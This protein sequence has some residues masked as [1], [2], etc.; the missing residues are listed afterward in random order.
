MIGVSNEHR[1]ASGLAAGDEV[2]VELVLDTAPRTVERAG[3]LRRGARRRPAARA[4]ST[5]CRTATR[6]ATCRRSRARS[7]TRR[8]SAGS[9]SR[10]RRCARAGR[11]S[12][13]AL[14]G[15]R[16]GRPRAVRAVVRD[17]PRPARRRVARRRAHVSARRAAVEH[18]R[19]A[20]V[21]RRRRPRELQPGDR[22]RRLGGVQLLAR[23]HG[24]RDEGRRGTRALRGRRAGVRS[25]ACTRRTR[26]RG[27]SSSTSSSTRPPTTAS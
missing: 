6:A 13:R 8:G 12:R 14:D 19:G 26:R 4:T 23:R 9:R 7:R 10:S 24:R 25:T 21:V 15:V 17:V 2:D 20:A 11:A 3:R 1:A 18:D 5:S 16:G 27:A 22:G